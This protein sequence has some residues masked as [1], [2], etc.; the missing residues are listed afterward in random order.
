MQA[1]RGDLA[2]H[3]ERNYALALRQADRA[4]ALSPGYAAAHGWR[5]EILAVL[6]RTDEAIVEAERAVKL[7]PINPFPHFFLGWL[8]DLA[9]DVVGAERDFRAAHQMAPG[10]S[11]GAFYTRLLISQA[12]HGEALAVA[13]A[14][15]AAHANA[16]NL[17]N[18]AVA[19]ILAGQR[20][21]ALATAARVHA[22]AAQ[23]WI[24]PFEFACMD[25]A[26]GNREDALRH[27]RES[28]E[29]RDFRI[30]FFAVDSGPEFDSMKDDPEFQRLIAII[31]EPASSP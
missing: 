29:V 20:Q 5:S 16:S 18:L 19:Q 10:F 9:G 2:F 28:I 3:F 1:T 26:L 15:V 4:I 27:L 14:M 23:R 8:R 13:N 11:S 17:S 6:G 21:D 22:M 24:S 7:D 25:A 31:R 30:P 12:R